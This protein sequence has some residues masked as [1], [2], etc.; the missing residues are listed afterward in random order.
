MSS[1]FNINDKTSFNQVYDQ[2]SAHESRKKGDADS[3]RL[4]GTNLHTKS[5]KPSAIGSKAKQ[6]RAQKKMDALTFVDKSL[7][8]EFTKVGLP[9]SGDGSAKKILSDLRTQ[10]QIGSDRVTI[11]DLGTIH[12]ASI[13]EQRLVRSLDKKLSNLGFAK[14]SGAEFV[15]TLRK[16]G[17]LAVGN[18]TV[19]DLSTI[20][21]ELNRLETSQKKEVTAYLQ[22]NGLDITNRARLVDS[23]QSK[24]GLATATQNATAGIDQFIKGGLGK[25]ADKDTKW[26]I[27]DG[28]KGGVIFA[29]TE[30]AKSVLKFDGG[31]T[32]IGQDSY[33]IL[34]SMRK[35]IG[36]DS[37]P[38]IAPH[39]TVVDLS[40]KDVVLVKDKM[41][42]EAN[43]L[44]SEIAKNA[45][46]TAKVEKLNKKLE[47]LEGSVNTDGMKENLKTE[48]KVLKF[49]MVEGAQQ[50]NKLEPWEK[51]ALLR[52]EQFARNLGKSM[53]VL[54]F[55]GFNDHLN[56]G[57]A[58]RGN[59]ATNF[60]NLMINKQGHIHL[61]D[62]SMNPTVQTSGSVSLGPTTQVQQTR[63][64]GAT[65]LLLRIAGGPKAVGDEL[66][67]IYNL[68]I[69]K[70]HDS[71]PLNNIASTLFDSA[72]EG[73]QLFYKDDAKSETLFL[74]AVPQHTKNRFMADLMDG[75]LEGLQFLDKH[76][77]AI[78]NAVQ[79]TGVATY[80][81]KVVLGSIHTDLTGLD[82]PKIRSNL[83]QYKAQLPT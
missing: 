19:G 54:Q 73:A 14:N 26:S 10:N 74:D 60:S 45:S 3:L 42:D 18:I 67:A 9:D 28:G 4:E 61:I 2:F 62:P 6:E 55:L 36:G 21:G 69:D 20:S 50:A 59:N 46:D 22:K 7:R 39:M 44:K 78:G 13:D 17:R 31:N 68:S 75:M 63:F 16:Q 71:D 30:G 49:Q 40:A 83:A 76:S 48:P 66:D 25:A 82:L 65:D 38:F 56:M 11:A 52:S 12:T 70:C 24:Q 41:D 37:L 23:P 33:K 81:P 80:D 29:E 15:A 57:A 35:A 32:Q 64:R 51:M 72:G 53:A 58:A 27:S 1:H 47:R 5:G 43:R 79:Q 8:R 77:T 34:D